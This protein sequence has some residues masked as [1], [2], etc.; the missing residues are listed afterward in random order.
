MFYYKHK[1]NWEDVRELNVM[2]SW[3]IEERG[4][5]GY[6]GFLTMLE[7]KF[8]ISIIIYILSI[9]V[10]VYFGLILAMM[11]GAT[12]LVIFLNMDRVCT[13]LN[14]HNQSMA[15]QM[16]RADIADINRMGL[17]KSPRS[18]EPPVFIGKTQVGVP[19]YLWWVHF[20]G[21]L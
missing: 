10:S 15:I 13:R 5:V 12:F 8:L 7:F 16:V 20:K 6:I 2:Y 9:Y 3:W 1:Y 17:V 19:R 21:R 18:D 14:I 4:W 11:Y